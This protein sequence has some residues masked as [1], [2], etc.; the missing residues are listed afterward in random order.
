[1]STPIILAST[2]QYRKQILAKLDFPFSSCDPR[3][4]EAH[5]VHESPTELVLRLA[6]A[7]AKAGALLYP[8]G[9]VIGSDQ[10]A[11]I[12]GKIIGKPLNHDTAVKQLTASSGKVITFY[13]GI[14]L[15]N[16][17][18]GHNES[19]CETFKVH[20]KHLSQQQIEH[21][22]LREQPYYCAGSFMCEGLG[23]ALFERLEGKDP[24]T[25]IGLPLITLTEM[26]ASQGYD[27]LAQ[28]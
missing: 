22:L 14:S 1:M 23:I 4:D 18:S 6:E 8:E 26:L 16:I 12:D 17:V 5:L 11:V 13:T 2:S 9:L 3:V 15:H 25:L 24:N 27:V 28:R 20:F 21:Y 19:H 7:K 10:V